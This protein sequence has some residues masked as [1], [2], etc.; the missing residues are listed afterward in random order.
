M[1]NNKNFHYV[2]CGI[3]TAVCMLWIAKIGIKFTWDFNHYHLYV[4]HAWW[5]NRL[6]EELFAAGAQGYLNP[7]PHLPF[8]FAYLTGAST[9]FVS[10]LMAWLHSINLW[11][12]H[13]I[14]CQ[15]IAPT[16]RIARLAIFCAVILGFLSPGFLFEVG[17]SYVDIVTSIPALGSLAALLF[18]LKKEEREFDRRFV[19]L[20]G[21]LSGI[22]LG[23]KPSSLIF[24]VAV[25]LAVLFLLRRDRFAFAWQA[26]LSAIFGAVL[27]GGQ[28]AWMLWNAFSNP[29]FPLF[30]GY[31]SSDWFFPVNIVSERFRPDGWHDVLMLPISMADSA[32]RTGFEAM[33]VDIRPMWLVGLAMLAIVWNFWRPVL[34]RSGDKISPLVQRVFWMI[35]LL[36][37]PLWAYSSNNIRYAVPFLLLLGPAIS[38]LVLKLQSRR[39]FFPMF[40]LL[41]PVLAQGALASNLN[42][43]NIAESEGWGWS[44]SWISLSVPPPLNQKAAYYLSLQRLSYGSFAVFFPPESR[45]FNLEGF[46]PDG[47]VFRAVQNLAKSKNLDFRTL[48]VLTSGGLVYAIAEQNSRLSDYGYRVNEKDCQL[49]KSPVYDLVLVSCAVEASQ[50]LEIA[51]HSRREVIDRR[52]SDW[53]HKCPRVFSPPGQWSTQTTRSRYRYYPASDFV[54]SEKKNELIALTGFKSNAVVHLENTRGERLLTTCPEINPK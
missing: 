5:Q 4:A 36:F 32:K 21:F 26:V 24:C 19:Y 51:E 1:S 37:T 49:I 30:N 28:H 47:K 25:F 22:S 23:L 8:Y 50:P 7:F 35:F 13:F 43:P 16:T 20:A 3:Y 41:L 17:G 14:A 6:P 15:L 12:L 54:I 29:V 34:I 10:L 40:A 42:T 33:T 18:F 53:E 44:N 9:F 27:V 45:F 52:I 31:F 11:L 38:L 39:P 2:S 46:P 48:R